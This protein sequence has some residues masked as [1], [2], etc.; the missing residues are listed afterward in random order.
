MKKSKF[1]PLGIGLVGLA[2]QGFAMGREA[3]TG[4]SY[5]ELMIVGLLL[6]VGAFVVMILNRRRKS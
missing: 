4:E 2:L 6:T 3:K 5:N 1:I